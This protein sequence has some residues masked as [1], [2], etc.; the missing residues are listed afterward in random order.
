MYPE[1]CWAGCGL[2]DAI[3]IRAKRMLHTE[4]SC[5]RRRGVSFSHAFNPVFPSGGSSEVIVL[6]ATYDLHECVFGCEEADVG[7]TEAG[8]VSQLIVL[9]THE[10]DELVH[11]IYHLVFP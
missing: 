1:A 5:W 2:S 4:A 9:A 6:S 7:R 10:H 11:D 3:R 8:D